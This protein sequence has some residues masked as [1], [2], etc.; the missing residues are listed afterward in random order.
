[1]SR[2]YLVQHGEAKPTDEDPERPL[3]SE[4]ERAVRRMAAFAAKVQLHVDEIRHSGKRR[5]QQTAAIFAERLK[6]RGGVVAVEGL[7]PNDDVKPL[8]RTLSDQ[9]G[10]IMLVGHLPFLARLAGRLVAGNAEREVVR[11][12]MGGIVCLERS[13][14]GRWAVAWAVTPELLP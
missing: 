3:T 10:P 13:E 5:A 4:G 11:F 7:A 9:T 14:E 12:R 6:L 2:V 1:M 8:A